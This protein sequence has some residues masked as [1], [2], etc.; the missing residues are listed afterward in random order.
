MKKQLLVTATILLMAL[1]ATAQTKSDYE[2]ADAELNQV[3]NSFPE[4][5][6]N[7]LRPIQRA[8]IK[9]KETCNN[10]YGCLTQRTQ[11]R[12]RFFKGIKVCLEQTGKIDCLNPR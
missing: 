9:G 8:W 2:K 7:A 11:Q 1:P 4:T 10:D 6:R 5:V 3:W 12:V